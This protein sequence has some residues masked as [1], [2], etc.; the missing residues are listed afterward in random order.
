VG[1][2]HAERYV[3]YESDRMFTAEGRESP[4]NEAPRAIERL[5]QRAKPL[6]DEFLILPFQASNTQ[7]YPFSWHSLSSTKDEL[8]AALL[9]VIRRYEERF[10]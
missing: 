4:A 6:Y 10:R 3:S 8:N 1:V 2:N 9:R 7:P 5:L